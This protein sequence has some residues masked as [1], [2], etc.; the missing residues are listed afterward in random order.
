VGDLVR[1]RGQSGRGGGSEPRKRLRTKAETAIASR[2]Y[3]HAVP[4]GDVRVLRVTSG[5]GGWVVNVSKLH[6]KGIPLPGRDYELMSFDTYRQFA[7]QIRT[8]NSE[9]ITAIRDE[10][11]T[12][13]SA[14]RAI[15]DD[16][17]AADASDLDF[18]EYTGDRTLMDVQLPS[19]GDTD[20]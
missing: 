6:R 18:L 15:L 10:Y 19:A 12:L 16:T 7:N 11:Y 2:Q 3:H 17:Q 1:T 9:V 20:R 8:G 13:S 5:V 14:R 4:W